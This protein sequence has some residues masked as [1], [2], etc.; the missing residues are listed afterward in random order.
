MKKG[1]TYHDYVIKDRKFIGRFD[2]V[3]AK[4]EDS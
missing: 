3:Y 2:E 4:F 1:E